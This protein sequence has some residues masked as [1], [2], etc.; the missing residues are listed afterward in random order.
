MCAC[1]YKEGA[2]I[3]AAKG[4]IGGGD[5]NESRTH[6]ALC[7]TNLYSVVPLGSK[8]REVPQC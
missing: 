2:E 7:V 8:L 6:F 5:G 1:A 4:E 3:E